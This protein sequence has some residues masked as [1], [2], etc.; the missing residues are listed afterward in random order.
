MMDKKKPPQAEERP[1]RRPR[2]FSVVGHDPETG[3]AQLREVP[4]PQL[5]T[6]LVE[7]QVDDISY[8]A[9]GKR[10]ARLGPAVLCDIP[11]TIWEE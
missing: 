9:L 8:L 7:E 3:R 6:I 10:R 4:R 2:F 5:P 1:E 11:M